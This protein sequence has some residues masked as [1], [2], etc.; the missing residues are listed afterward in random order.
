M[1]GN[2]IYTK[3]R[4]TVL[5]RDYWPASCSTEGEQW[6]DQV[7]GRRHTAT[8]IH[9]WACSARWTCWDRRRVSSTR[10]ETGTTS[11]WRRRVNGLITHMPHHTSSTGCTNKKQSPRKMLYFSHG[12]TDLSQTFRLCIWVLMQHIL[13]ILGKLLIWFFRYSSLNFKVHFFKW[14]C[15]CTLN[16]HE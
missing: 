15:S 3:Q 13:W 16:I 6:S 8:M 9:S 1:A 10:R 2:Q 4:Q 12:S 7:R 11:V 14:T 5:T